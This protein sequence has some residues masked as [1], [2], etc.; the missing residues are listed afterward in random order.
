[1]PRSANTIMQSDE[2]RPTTRRCPSVKRILIDC[3][4]TITCEFNSGIQRVVRS[5]CQQAAKH[6]STIQFIP[7]HGNQGRY[8]KAENLWPT[9]QNRKDWI[10]HV[11][12]GRLASFYRKA[13]ASIHRRFPNKKFKK[14][15]LPE[16]GHAGIFKVP[17]LAIQGL[18]RMVK[19]RVN[20]SR[21]RNLEIIIH[22]GDV[23]LLADASW[24]QPNWDCIESAR[25]QGALIGNLIYDLI[26]ITHA[27]FFQS[28]LADRFA[29]WFDRAIAEG[30]FFLCI[31]ECVA[32]QMRDQM[33]RMGKPH[34]HARQV[35]L[36]FP[37]GSDLK[38]W[39]VAEVSDQFKAIFRNDRQTNPHFVVGTIEPRKNHTFILEAF[40]KLWQSGSQ[41]RLCVAGRIGW[42]CNELAARILNHAEFNKKLFMCNQASDAD[43]GFGYQNAKSLIM[44][45]HTEGFGLPIVEALALRQTVLAS[46]TPIHREVGADSVRYFKI[47][48]DCDTLVDAINTLAAQ[49]ISPSSGRSKYSATP[50]SESYDKVVSLIVEIAHYLDTAQPISQAG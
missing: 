46:D 49:N 8:H 19:T 5:L 14:L 12:N 41:E 28:I 25:A 21:R 29:R 40:E 33:I 45:S 17:K 30:D 24:E 39:D 20:A 35:C 1:M 3:S 36:G 2:A 11:T 27:H 31:S 7:V 50:W 44:A 15:F 37:L 42:N 38:T 16:K 18:E 47:D 34:D 43:I 9:T 13:A 32:Q 48:A 10:S 23:L 4:S 26:P 22:E 6:P